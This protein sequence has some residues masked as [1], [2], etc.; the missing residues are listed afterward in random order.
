MVL[1]LIVQICFLQVRGN[2]PDHWSV[3]GGAGLHHQ[4]VVLLNF[5]ESTER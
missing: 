4:A 2:Y 5:V 1:G 3:G